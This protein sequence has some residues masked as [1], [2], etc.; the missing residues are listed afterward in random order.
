MLIGS[1]K[2]VVL[3]IALVLALAAGI[4][5]WKWQST[6]TYA[7]PVGRFIKRVVDPSPKCTFPQCIECHGDAILRRTALGVPACCVKFEEYDEKCAVCEYIDAKGK[8][9]IQVS[10]SCPASVKKL[11]R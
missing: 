8:T 3:G 2:H 9:K 7:A 10:D 4:A 1:R 6:E 11:Y 5:W